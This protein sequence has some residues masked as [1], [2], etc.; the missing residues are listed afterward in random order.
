M[1]EREKRGSRIRRKRSRTPFNENDWL[2]FVFCVLVLQKTVLLL[3]ILFLFRAVFGFTQSSDFLHNLPI[4]V[5]KHFMAPWSSL[6]ISIF[7]MIHVHIYKK[8]KLKGK[9]EIERELHR[10]PKNFYTLTQNLKIF[11]P[12]PKTS[13]L[14]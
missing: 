12:R 9:I 2:F 14:C 3:V 6:S 5:K 10:A 7:Y 8:L 11:I 4:K 1:R 13:R